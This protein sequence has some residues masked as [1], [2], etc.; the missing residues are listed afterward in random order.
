MAAGKAGC[1]GIPVVAF[2]G[3]SGSG[4]TTLIEALLP[5]LRRRGLR[6]AVVKHDAHRFDV[7]RP[8]KDSWRFT[9]AG[10][11]VSV[12]SSAEKT[13]LIE[14][15]E[16]SLLE[17][18]GRVRDVDLILVEGYKNEPLT[19]IGICRAAAGKDF[20][21]PLNRFIAVVTDR[22][23]VRADVPV[24]FLSDAEGIAEFLLNH[25]EHLTHFCGGALEQPA[26]Q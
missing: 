17:I 22:A 14:R 24:F 13:A 10:A 6:V 21:A 23:D 12:I 20:T 11:E 9:Q 26:P 25:L 2:A 16:L 18:L 7:D 1:R 4:K 15:R 19:Q 8:G 5:C 3:Y